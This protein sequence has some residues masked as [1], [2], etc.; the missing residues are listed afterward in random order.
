MAYRNYSTAVG[1]IVDQ[2]GHGDF[3]TI[4]AALASAVSGET[5]FVRPGTYTENITLVAGVNLT[6]FGNVGN[7][8]VVIN[9]QASLSAAGTVSI[10]GITFQSNGANALLISGSGHTVLNLTD[11][12]ISATNG[13][14]I[15]YTN[16]AAT[17]VVTLN[18]CAGDILD[19]TSAIFTSS[20]VGALSFNDCAF[21]NTSLSTT[22]NTASAGVVGAVFCGFANPITSSGTASLEATWCGFNTLAIHTVAMT[23]GGSGGGNLLWCD[24]VTDGPECVV[25]N[26]SCSIIQCVLGTG[27]ANAIT[28][29]GTLSAGIITFTGGT[30]ITT[31]VVIK[32][33]TY[34]G[35]IV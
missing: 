3:S 6:A 5:I 15:H 13:T 23:Q 10:S 16:S 35:T 17:S 21:S 4:T 25:V 28:G 20:S 7:E 30:T 31:A 1:H 9:G 27:G 24:F 14:A 32:L 12:F 22:A 26:N 2:N 18:D 29:A 34:G 8:H 11:C 33:T 19:G